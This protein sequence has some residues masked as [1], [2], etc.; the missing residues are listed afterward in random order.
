MKNTMLVA[1]FGILFAIGLTS[2]VGDPPYN[3][4]HC[5]EDCAIFVELGFFQGQGECRHACSTCNIALH[6]NGANNAATFANCVCNLTAS[7]F[8]LEAAGFS[9]HGD[10]LK[11][12]KGVFNGN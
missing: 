9:N 6:E 11:F 7:F 3:A 8:G 4:Q 12:Y 2:M 1:A 10:C 5:N